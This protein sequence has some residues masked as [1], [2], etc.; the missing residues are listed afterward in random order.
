[1]SEPC[2]YQLCLYQ[3]PP[4]SPSPPPPTMGT[5]IR[6]TDGRSGNPFVPSPSLLVTLTRHLNHHHHH[7][8]YRHHYHLLPRHRRR[9]RH[10]RHHRRQILGKA[11]YFLYVRVKAGCAG[12]KAG[13]RCGESVGCRHQN[14]HESL[15][16]FEYRCMNTHIGAVNVCVCVCVCVCV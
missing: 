9:R 15:F 1:M 12:W 10:R 6:A 2:F 7:H 16:P 4:P 5:V 14:A 13:T 11:F 3:E 8:H